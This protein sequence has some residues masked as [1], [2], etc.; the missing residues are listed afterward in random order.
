MTS[1]PLD[2]LRLE[3][4]P[5]MPRKGFAD[6]L[7]RRIRE[8][9]SAPEDLD[10]SERSTRPAGT[11][12]RAP[13]AEMIGDTTGPDRATL[14]RQESLSQTLDAVE[15]L[16][17]EN[18]TLSLDVRRFV[19]RWIA[20]RQGLPQA[21]SG[22]FAGFPSELRDGVVVF[23]GERF[24]RASARHVLGEEACRV[25]RWLDVHEPE[26]EG[27]L[28][29]ADRGLTAAVAHAE[30]DPRYGN[31]PGAYCCTK[32]TVGMWRNLVSGGLDRHEERLRRGAGQFL[33]SRRGEGRWRSFP[34]W[35]TVLALTEMDVPEARDELEFVA[36]ALEP[37]ARRAAPEDTY[38][39][40]RHE[41][42][43]R[44]LSV[45]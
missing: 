14:V 3:S 4:T 45:L 30:H 39:Q 18:R 33:R 38:G 25:L 5:A 27:A 9:L 44:A 43:S 41:V 1:D 7:E 42:A 37:T 20:A 19:A 34:F 35:Y 10:V 36:P 22:T 24:T 31:N 13:A 12:R 2:R 16:A 15:E 40:R 32:C 6:E 8:A 11:A 23:T 21:K 29:R 28:E 17:F 26:V